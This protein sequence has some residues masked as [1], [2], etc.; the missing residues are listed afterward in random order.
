MHLYKYGFL[1]LTPPPKWQLYH[2]VPKFGLTQ[3]I[4]MNSVPHD[5]KIFAL[6][7]W[8]D[9]H[10]R[11]WTGQLAFIGPHHPSF[12][13]LPKSPNNGRGFGANQR[14]SLEFPFVVY[15]GGINSVGS[16]GTLACHVVNCLLLMACAW[17][18]PICCIKGS[19]PQR[20]DSVRFTAGCRNIRPLKSKNF[21]D[22]LNYFFL[23]CSK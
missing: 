21:P 3:W 23:D 13:V 4:W 7:M 14:I 12:Q 10:W 19:N 17:Q 2:F 11:V 22:F 16:L 15:L 5:Q 6:A 1:C 20:C 9:D 18:R 8:F